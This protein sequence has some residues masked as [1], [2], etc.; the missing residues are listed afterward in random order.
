[1]KY[2]G[3][4][5]AARAGKDTFCKYFVE[6]L[7]T[8]GLVGTRYALADNLKKDLYYF[9]KDKFNRDI[10][11]LDGQDKEEIRPL[12]V[13]YG[14]AKRLQSKG[15]YWTSL[16][17]KQFGGYNEDVAIV[18][19]LRYCFYENDEHW[20]MQKRLN[21]KIIHITRTITGL[22]GIPYVNSEEATFDPKM[23]EIADYKLVIPTFDD[24][25]DLR[26]FIF[27]W[28]EQHSES[29]TQ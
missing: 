15:T 16:V 7:K 4:S 9:V 2:I 22:G 14:A 11:N 26:I 12:M 18:T 5:G 25:E 3:L 8:K 13:G 1:M 20:W 21:G 10:N 23:R 6:F 29:W 27:D 17:E 19:D 24:L 28:L